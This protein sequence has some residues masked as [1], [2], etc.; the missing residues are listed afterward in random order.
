MK[1]IT[2]K[3]KLYL[4]MVEERIVKIKEK[5]KNAKQRN[6]LDYDVDVLQKALGEADEYA[7]KLKYIMSK[8]Y[9][10]YNESN[11]AL[12]KATIVAVEKYLGI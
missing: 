8:C 2:S 6:V 4:D 10:E 12:C 5:L 7:K 1:E 11:I 3:A 9:D